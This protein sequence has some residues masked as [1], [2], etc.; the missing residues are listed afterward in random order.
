MAVATDPRPD[1]GVDAELLERREVLPGR[2]QLTLAAPAIARGVAPGQFVYLLEPRTPG[3]LLPALPVA[4]FDRVA[5]TITLDAVPDAATSDPLLRLRPGERAMLAGPLG[6]AFEVDPRSRYVLLVADADGLARVRA[7]VDEAVAT[8]RQ[9]TLLLE[10]ATVADVPPSSLLPDEVEYVIATRDGSLGHRGV[11]S[12]LVPD[13]EAWAD[14]CFA[15]GSETLLARLVA[16]ARGRD[17]RMGVAR[18]GRRRGRRP[19]PRSARSRRR[20]WLQ[21]ALP[22]PA[23]CALAVCLGCVRSGEDGPLR[24]CREGPV[25]PAD[26]LRWER[27]S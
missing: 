23:G 5:G 7:S 15:A 26:T 9:V 27:R 14:Q 21:V 16:L 25:F 6:R 22:H 24:V 18:L 8:G 2:W 12:E 4:G 19:D 11:V 1:G 17:A 20:A 13:Y 3:L 10:A